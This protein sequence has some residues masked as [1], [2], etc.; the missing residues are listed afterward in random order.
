MS[1]LQITTENGGDLRRV[2]AVGEVDLATAE[3]F[4]AAIA[5][6]AGSTVVVDLAG[7]SFMDSSGIVALET[8][9]RQ[10][11]AEGHRLEIRDAQRAVRRVF[12]ILGIEDWLTE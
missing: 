4:R 1:G 5:E 3:Q 9:R 7:V 11:E 8:A 10:I 6:S 2:I 12:E